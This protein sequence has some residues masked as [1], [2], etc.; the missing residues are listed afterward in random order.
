MRFVCTILGVVLLSTAALAESL[1]VTIFAGSDAGP[2]YRDGVG[3]AARFDSPYALTVDAS[4]NILVGDSSAHNI[5]Q[6]TPSGAVS[7]LA[8]VAG[9]SGGTDGRNGV[10]RFNG[11]RALAVDSSGNVYVAEWNLRRISPSGAVTTLVPSMSSFSGLAV[12]S[13][14]TVFATDTSNAAIR[15]I[16]PGGTMTTF[17]ATAHAPRGLTIDGS[18]NLYF[19]TDGGGVYKCTPQGVITPIASGVIYPG[20]LDVDASG[21]LYV[22]SGDQVKKVTPA[23]P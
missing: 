12:D 8:G 1:S 2:G 9:E 21:N 20:D 18:N 19:T 17:V 3:N 7:T 11:P 4:G 22:L 16:T 15:R 23:G 6:I 13:R 10:A 14:G 5:R